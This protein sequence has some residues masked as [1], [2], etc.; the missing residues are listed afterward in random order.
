VKDQ[1]RDLGINIGLLVAGFAGSLVMMK[2][3]GHK[4]WFSTITSLLAGTLSA[5]YLTP[6]VVDF[7]NI[8]NSNTQYA[9]AFIMGFL[10]LHGVEYIL[11]RFG[12][13]Q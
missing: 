12:P 2:K 6:V 13:K 8:G 7:M 1:L 11:N 4:D 5:N 3:D 9:A 10:G